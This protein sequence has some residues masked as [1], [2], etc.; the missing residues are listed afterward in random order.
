M[1]PAKTEI[2]EKWPKPKILTELCGFLGLVQFFKQFIKNFSDIAKPLTD[3]TKKFEG[4][5]SWY[6]KS[7]DA[8]KQVKTLLATYPVL[9]APNWNNSFT[10]HVDSS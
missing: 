3:L 4:I 2:I 9:A 6:S 10:L 8:F 7:D 1:D 5:E